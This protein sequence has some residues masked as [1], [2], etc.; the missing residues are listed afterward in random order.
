MDERKAQQL[1]SLCSRRFCL[2]ECL[3]RVEARLEAC[4]APRPSRRVT[5]TQRRVCGVQA[6]ELVR[7]VFRRVPRPQRHV[8]IA[9][10]LAVAVAGRRGGSHTRGGGGGARFAVVPFTRRRAALGAMAFMRRL[11]GRTPPEGWDAIESSVEE[12][13]TQMRDAVAED[14][15][16][17]RKNETAWRIH[18]VHFEKNRFFH[19]LMYKQKAMSRELVRHG[20][21]KPLPCCC[22]ARCAARPAAR[23]R[24]L[25]TQATLPRTAHAL[26]RRGVQRGRGAGARRVALGLRCL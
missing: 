17:K 13:E 4:S 3:K 16:G 14:H 9:V 10:R 23:K 19:D 24:A 21:R 15:E 1:Q 6:L 5:V 8:L 11:K 2:C 12:Y 26:L 7:A 25:P 20:T 18:R 22:A